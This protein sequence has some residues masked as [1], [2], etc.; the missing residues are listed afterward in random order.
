MRT[1]GRMHCT[2]PGA[3]CRRYAV[4]V[5]TAA[6]IAAGAASLAGA[7]PARGA[8]PAKATAGE[9]ADK[10]PVDINAADAEKLATLPG[11]GPSIAQRIVEY[12]KEHGP[13]KSVDELVNVRGVG[14]K[15]LGRLRDHITVGSKD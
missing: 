1:V 8:H 2:M 12:R 10:S 14:E 7:A 9:A 5:L 11:I 6:A 13:F 15:L 4:A 3:L